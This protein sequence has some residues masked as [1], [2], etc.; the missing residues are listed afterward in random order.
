MAVDLVDVV[1]AAHVRVRDLPR[2]PHFGVELRQARG[3]AIDVGRQEL[4]RDRL[5][6][7]QIVGA[8][9]L[10]HAAA[11]QP[12]DDAVAAAEKGS[13]GKR[14][15]SMAPEHESQPLEAEPVPAEL[16]RG[17]DGSLLLPAPAIV[18]SS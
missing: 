12:S 13:G 3:I 6:E 14:P 8:I 15:W 16:E 9:D 4:Q 7:L 11:A 5:A 2:H 1:D 18:G 10:A 17:R